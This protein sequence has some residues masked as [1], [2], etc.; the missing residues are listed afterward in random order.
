MCLQFIA[1]ARSS[2]TVLQLQQAVSI[3]E[4]FDVSLNTSNLIS[5]EKIGRRCTSLIR[6]SKDTED[7]ECFEFSHFS[8]KEFLT[9]ISLLDFSTLNIYHLT[10]SRSYKILV[11]QCL[12]FLQLENF[13][14]HSESSKEEADHI[15]SRN[16]ENPFYEH[17]AF[18]WPEYA[19]NHL[20]DPLLFNLACS[21]FQRPK[22]AHFLAWSVNVICHI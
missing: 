19:R 21:L 12:R 2:L 6:K 4:T 17:A 14:R 8:V 22:T 9:D 3:S 18:T 11:I 10:E 13:E 7:R 15:S 5:E 1:F 16:S 20:D